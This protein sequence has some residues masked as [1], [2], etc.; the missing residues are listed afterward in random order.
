MNCE[1]AV[2]AAIVETS[3]AREVVSILW[4]KS[5]LVDVV[6]GVK[7]LQIN[8][9]IEDEKASTVWRLAGPDSH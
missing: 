9:I 5:K 3:A 1:E 4:G 8:A 6:F 7:K 2:A